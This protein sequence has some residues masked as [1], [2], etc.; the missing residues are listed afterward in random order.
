[1]PAHHHP[2]QSELSFVPHQLWS[3]PRACTRHVLLST[4]SNKVSF[5]GTLF[6]GFTC[7]PIRSDACQPS[8]SP[9]QCCIAPTCAV[10]TLLVDRAGCSAS[11]SSLARQGVA[12]HI[13]SPFPPFCPIMGNLECFSAARACALMLADSIYSKTH[14]TTFGC[15][16]L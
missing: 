1:M 2:Q 12:R 9:P 8:P 10:C 13:H 5:S 7:T 14:V 15:M 6:A 16:S 11:C 3:Y 4:N